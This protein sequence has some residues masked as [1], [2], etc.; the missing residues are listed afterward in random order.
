MITAAIIVASGIVLGAL[1]LAFGP[2]VVTV[3]LQGSE[4][5]PANF[6]DLLTALSERV[7]SDTTVH[8]SV[9][10]FISNLQDQLKAALEI[11]KSAGVTDEQLVKFNALLAALDANHDELAA[12]ITANTPVSTDPNSPPPAAQ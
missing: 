6:D 1:I 3:L 10:T 5:M 9:K 7:A 2:A 11:A 8:G 12:A 4:T